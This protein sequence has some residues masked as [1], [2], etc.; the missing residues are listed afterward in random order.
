MIYYHL[1]EHDKAIEQA[2]KTLEMDPNFR[3]AH[4]YL[5]RIYSWIGMHEEALRELELINYKGARTG[6][7]Y[8]KM[9]RISEAR[10]VLEDSIRQSQQSNVPNYIIA[11]IYFCI[12]DKDTGFAYLEKSYEEHENGMIYIKIDPDIDKDVRSDPRFKAFLKKMNL[13]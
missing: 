11:S 6:V 12:G 5:A 8:A 4:S 10:R 3:P 1:D 9:G 7:V 2:K 13:E